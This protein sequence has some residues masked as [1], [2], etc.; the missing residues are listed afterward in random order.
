ME[1][2][3]R[4]FIGSSVENL[5]VAYAIQENLEH[6]AICTVRDQG[7]FELS[8][9]ALDSL[10]KATNN[11]DFAIFIFNPDDITKIRNV[12]YSTVRDNLVFELGL[13]IGKLGRNNVFF[14]IPRDIDK[15]HLPTDLIGIEPGSYEIPSEDK[16]LRSA[17][18]P[19]CNKVR[20]K[21]KDSLIEMS[22]ESEK[23]K[24]TDDKSVPVE[25]VKKKPE[26]KSIEYGVS[27]DTTGKYIISVAPTVFFSYRI[28]K[29]F[30]GIR[31]FKWFYDPKEALDRLEILLKS[32]LSFDEAIGYGVSTE[33]VWWSR[34][35]NDLAI[36]KFIRIS[37]NKC[38]MDEEELEISKI[39]VFHSNRY[40]QS[41]VYVEVNG[42][43]PI[44]LYEYKKAELDKWIAEYGY[45]Q[46]EYGLFEGTPITRSCYDDGAAE[47]NG[48]VVDTSGAELRVRYL[49]KYNF[50][51]ASR[52]APIVCREF[53]KYSKKAFNN[54]LNGLDTVENMTKFIQ[55]LPRHDKDD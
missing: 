44:G 50:V 8:A 42:E 15:L 14:L 20:R 10:L 13:F 6:N 40:W 47:I 36:R 35:Y 34:G 31:G 52:F 41:F 55:N 54:I 27:I 53:E 33:P 29:A 32:P 9:S 46:E 3:P 11:Y 12:E 45:Y 28:A 1:N 25:S 17:L 2:K 4:L 49:S 23:T 37:E 26:L 39:A 19:F 24:I 48:K 22:E 16:Y 30:P 38:L 51:I 18:G 7:I 43:P 21:I 5:D